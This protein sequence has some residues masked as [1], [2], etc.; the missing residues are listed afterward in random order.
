MGKFFSF[1]KYNK[2]YKYIWIAI[3]F[4]L[5]YEYLFSETFPSQI[6]FNFLNTQNY[7]PDILVQL[8]FNYLG[9]S[10][11]GIFLFIYERKQ[12]KN[13]DKK[14]IRNKYSSLVTEHLYKKT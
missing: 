7:P 14:I 11:L 3:I 8:F 10:F 12:S 5:I 6:R 2:L 13:I 1:G 4:K 9:S